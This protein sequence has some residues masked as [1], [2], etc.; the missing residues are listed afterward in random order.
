MYNVTY[1]NAHFMGTD[2][3]PE[4][5]FDFAI[6]EGPYEEYDKYVA[7]MQNDPW[8]DDDDIMSLEEYIENSDPYNIFYY[9]TKNGQIDT[10]EPIFY[11]LNGSVINPEYPFASG[12]MEALSDCIVSY[13]YNKDPEEYELT[14]GA[15]PF[16]FD[17]CCSDYGADD[18]FL[19][20]C[21][22]DSLSQMSK[23]YLCNCGIAEEAN[24]EIIPMSK[25][26]TYRDENGKRKT[27]EVEAF[28]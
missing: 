8:C 22:F 17:M 13:L 21:G 15:P 26:T 20:H 1:C 19:N 9:F 16:T 25:F 4:T 12:L 7:N 2:L 14:Y 18:D 23:E 24:W 11:D 6:Y 10:D 28:D 27:I 5:S 3:L